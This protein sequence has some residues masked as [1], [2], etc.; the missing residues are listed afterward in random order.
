MIE[1]L[2]QAIFSIWCRFQKF[3]PAGSLYNP[4]LDFLIFNC[5]CFFLYE[6]TTD[7]AC[8]IFGRT[9]FGTIIVSFKIILISI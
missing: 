6:W 2:L 9:Y 5:L 7:L 1:K 4:A 8:E 3:E